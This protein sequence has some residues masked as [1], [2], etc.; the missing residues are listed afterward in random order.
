MDLWKSTNIENK[1]INIPTLSME[2]ESKAIPVTGC[3]GL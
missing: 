3:G 1:A 2:S